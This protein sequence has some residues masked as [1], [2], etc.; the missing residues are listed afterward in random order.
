MTRFQEYTN[1]TM[2]PTEWQ[3]DALYTAYVY[4]NHNAVG[5]EFGWFVF[6]KTAFWLVVQSRSHVCGFVCG[7]PWHL[8][9]N[10]CKHTIYCGMLSGFLSRPTWATRIGSL[11][12]KRVA[13]EDPIDSS[14]VRHNSTKGKGLARLK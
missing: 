12:N 6:C 9:Y 3:L 2:Q 10:H 1:C 13:N 14:Y 11:N 5:N 8:K 7:C 4:Y